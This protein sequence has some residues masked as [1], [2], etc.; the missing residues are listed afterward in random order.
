[1]KRRSHGF[2]LLELMITLALA[3]VIL[4]IGVPNFR[5]FTRNNRMVTVANELLS[6]VITAR[7][8]AIKRQVPVAVC[9]SLEPIAEDPSC[10]GDSTRQ[11]NGW[12]AFE[13]KNNNCVRDTGEDVLRVG[14]RI[15]LNNSASHYVKSKS[16]GSC[17][18]FAPTGFLQKKLVTGR[19]EATY[20]VFCDERGYTEQQGT[21]LMVPRGV[22]VS[23][24]GRAH[25]TRDKTE[26]DSWGVGC[27]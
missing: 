3:A 25:V 17:I 26:L 1:M 16:N 20:T 23:L 7:T 4:A 22:E 10:M 18:S 9:P 24:T 15:D 6:G 2:T 12:I 11:F 14:A 21:S 5:E 19:Q 13:D 27:P 8:E